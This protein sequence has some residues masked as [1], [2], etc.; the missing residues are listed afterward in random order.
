MKKIFFA[1]YKYCL[2][3]DPNHTPNIF[4]ATLNDLRMQIWWLTITDPAL[5]LSFNINHFALSHTHKYL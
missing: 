3:F 5:G 1:E 4:K 2:E